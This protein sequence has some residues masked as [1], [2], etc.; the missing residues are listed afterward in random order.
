MFQL[1]A[2][3]SSK[4]A[5]DHG[6]SKKRKHTKK[7]TLA[8]AA[9]SEANP[10]ATPPNPT[11]MAHVVKKVLFCTIVEVISFTHFIQFRYPLVTQFITSLRP[12]LMVLM[13]PPVVKAINI[14]GVTMGQGKFL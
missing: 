2:I 5:P 9:P 4:M 1:A 14:I 10:L 13:G 11:A 3:L 7:K 12:F 6:H 8:A